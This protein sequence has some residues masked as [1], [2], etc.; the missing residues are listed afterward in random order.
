MARDDDA[1]QAFVKTVKDGEEGEEREE[2]D[3]MAMMAA[4]LD[5]HIELEFI[6]RDLAHFLRV[7]MHHKLRSLLLKVAKQTK[8]PQEGH[9]Q[10]ASRQ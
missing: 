1:S 9:G 6:P 4:R 7:P 3:V 10:E 8:G 5:E 2:V